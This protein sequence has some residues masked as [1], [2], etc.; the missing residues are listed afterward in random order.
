[1][2]IWLIGK[3]SMKHSY[4]KKMS[5]TVTQED[6]ETENLRE[7]NDLYVQ[8]DTLLLGDVFENFR[9]ICLETYELNPIK[10]RSAPG[11]A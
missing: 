1:M 9:N 10:F 7:Y 6:F 3:N 8:R 4:L 11:L 5:F 2:N